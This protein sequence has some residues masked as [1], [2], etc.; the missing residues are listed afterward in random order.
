MSKTQHTMDKVTIT[1][2]TG[3][4]TQVRTLSPKEIKP[5]T[6]YNTFHY[7]GKDGE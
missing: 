1:T 7:E 2:R 4:G 6:K 5:N 3:T